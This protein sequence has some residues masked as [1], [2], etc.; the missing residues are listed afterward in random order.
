MSKAIA[1]KPRSSHLAS[2]PH[3]K[4]EARLKHALTHLSPD[5]LEVSRKAEAHYA[6]LEGEFQQERQ[7][8]LAAVKRGVRPVAG[9]WKLDQVRLSSPHRWEQGRES[10][11]LASAYEADVQPV[12]FPAVPLKIYRDLWHE[13]AV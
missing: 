2:C 9:Q 6:S 1:P 12:H 7:A 13:E 11:P 10:N 8:E 5:M 4:S 3:C